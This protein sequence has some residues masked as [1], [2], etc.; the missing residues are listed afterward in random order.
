[1]ADSFR[2]ANGLIHISSNTTSVNLVLRGIDNNIA[3]AE[4]LYIKSFI[5]HLFPNND[6]DDVYM[7][8][9][10]TTIRIK[11]ND[12]KF[13]PQFIF[14]F[15]IFYCILQHTS[16]LDSIKPHQGIVLKCI[17][18]HICGTANTL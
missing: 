15:M 17:N 1:M 11:D 5:L 13:I 6:D 4:S 9:N 18:I 14:I 8:H 10:T 12:S 16:K 2:T 3:E 7:P